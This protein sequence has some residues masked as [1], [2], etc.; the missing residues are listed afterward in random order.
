ML[1]T[2]PPCIY[3]DTSLFALSA[4]SKGIEFI[5]DIQPFYSLPLLGDR[6]RFRQVLAN[7]VSNAVKFTKEGSVKFRVEQE[8]ENASH[9]VILFVVTDSGVGI[10]ESVVPNLFAPFQ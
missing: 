8:F 3:S 7:I 1:V 6:V 4:R 5:K 2:S 9:A 10:Q